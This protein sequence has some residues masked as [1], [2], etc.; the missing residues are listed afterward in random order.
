WIEELTSEC[1]NRINKRQFL[2]ADN[3]R[4]YPEPEADNAERSPE[5]VKHFDHKYTSTI[6]NTQEISSKL[7]STSNLVI[8]SNP[9]NSLKIPD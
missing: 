1:S 2:K 3:V 7:M 8:I 9:I 4:P 6:I 5:P